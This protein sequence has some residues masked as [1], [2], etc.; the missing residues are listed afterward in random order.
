MDGF[1][2]MF[3]M[4]CAVVGTLYILRV[5]LQLLRELGGGIL[6]YILAHL[7][8][9]GGAVDLLDY[10]PWAVVTG[11]S[12][13]IGRG[14]A[15]ELARRGLN[16]VLLSRSREKL[17]KV[18]KEIRETHGRDALVIPVDFTQGQAVYEKLQEELSQLEIGLL[19]NNVGLSHKYAQYF[20]EVEGQRARDMIELNCQAMVQMTHLLLPRMVERRRGAVINISSYLATH[21]Q[22][23]LGLYSAT[24]KFANFFSQALSEEYSQRG[25]LVQTVMPH[26]VSTAMTKIRRNIFVPTG[27]VYSR[28][29]V[30]TVGVVNTTYGYLPHAIICYLSNII[31]R[32]ITSRVA[33]ALL[34]YSRSRYF[35]LTSSRNKT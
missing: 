13:G 9:G 22:P 1:L 11:A 14:Y 21:P 35:R 4:L 8:L 31:P 2:D 18:A 20:L 19:V 32:F 7:G 25:V 5:T 30:G 23:L 26:L 12:E 15:L 33:F 34:S 17:E 6:V 10:G 16:V 28:S 3:W 24:K 29:A 27:T